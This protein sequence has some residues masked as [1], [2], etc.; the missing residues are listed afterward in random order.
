MEEGLNFPENS[1]RSGG[2]PPPPGEL[3]LNFCQADNVQLGSWRARGLSGTP[4][5]KWKKSL[6]SSPLWP[7][8]R[9]R[10]CFSS[11]KQGLDGH[12][13]AAIDSLCWLHLCPPSRGFQMARTR[14]SEQHRLSAAYLVYDVTSEVPHGWTPGNILLAFTINDL[15]GRICERG[16]LRW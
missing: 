6:K 2:G 9:N 10:P 4:R 3:E 5:D 15:E 12:C 1:W 13:C 11:P 16:N 8:I 7:Q 14:Y